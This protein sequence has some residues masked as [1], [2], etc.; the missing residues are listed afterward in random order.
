M[1]TL[2]QIINGILALL[3]IPPSFLL[4]KV[5]LKER[6][7]ISKKQDNLNKILAWLFLGIAIGSIINASI[8]ITYI[9]GVRSLSHIIS[10]YRSLFLNMFFSCVSWILYLYQKSIGKR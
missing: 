3:A 1:N 2:L 4:L 5:V 10:P 6:Y 9:I 8:S 7:K